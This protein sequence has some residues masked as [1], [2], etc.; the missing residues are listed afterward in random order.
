MLYSKAPLWPVLAA[1][2]MGMSSVAFADTTVSSAPNAFMVSFAGVTQEETVLRKW[3]V[4][5][6]GTYTFRVPANSGIKVTINGALLIDASGTRA[7]DIG[8]TI[9]AFVSLEAGDHVVNMTG[10]SAENANIP[11]ITVNAVGQDPRPLFEVSTGIDGAEVNAIAASNAGLVAPALRSAGQAAFAISG[12][13]ASRMTGADGGVSGVVMSAANSSMEQS[14][15]G[16]VSQSATMAEE[17]IEFPTSVRSGAATT[18]VASF[19][20]NKTPPT[21]ARPVV[22]PTPTTPV[23]PPTPTPPVITPPPT[24]SLVAAVRPTLPAQHIRKPANPGDG[25][26]V[27]GGDVSPLTP[28]TNPPLTQMIQ[29]TSIDATDGIVANTGA[30][31]FGAVQI[32]ALFDTIEVTFAPTVRTEPTIVSVGATGQFAVRMFEE[33]FSRSSEVRVTLVGK[34]SSNAAMSS[35]PVTY[36]VTGAPANTGVGKALSRLTFGPTPE[37]YAR[38]RAIGYEAFVREQLNPGSINNRAFRNMQTQDLLVTDVN[39]QSSIQRS[40]VHY[41]TANAMFNP[42][43]LQEVMG[44]FWANHFHAITKDSP[45]NIQ[46]QTDREFFRAN[47]LTNFEDMLLYSAKSPLMS[48]YLDNDANRVDVVRGVQLGINENY[49]REILELHTVGV[50]GGYDSDDIEAVAKIFTGWAYERTNPMAEQGAAQLYAFRFFPERHVAGPK[51]VPFLGVTIAERTGP[52]GVQ[53]GEELIGILA[54]HPSTR[55]FVCGKLV[56]FLVADQPPSNLIAACAAA[57]RASDGEIVPMLEAILL[58]PSYITTAEYQRNKVKNPFEYSVSIARAFGASPQADLNN[59]VINFYNNFREVFEAGG[60]YSM[61][62]AAPTGLPEVS[63]A[64]TSSATLAG[65]YTF[66]GDIA[67]SRQNYG[68][69]LLADIR[70]LELETAEEVAAYLLTVA[71]A[72]R[73]TKPEF[74]AVVDVLNGSNGFDVASE[75]FA[76]RNAVERAMG[77]ILVTPSFLLQ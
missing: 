5:S 68:I 32:D 19:V 18:G 54:Q 63:A 28:P 3:T 62:F 20:V 52:A 10:V 6:A 40:L 75:S 73:F 22:N 38:V 35:E 45:I 4:Q 14:S 23:T 34:M 24:A 49:A 36:T 2:S 39:T 26:D 70:D 17:K 15:L 25:V 48:Q 44:R 12:A 29:L 69:D 67:E 30:T 21:P 71:T 43:Q 33:D 65:L 27:R 16:S 7:D 58:D 74:D 41:D 76:T 77:L 47:S 55:S 64:W 56:Q 53:E 59:G 46:N 72:D 9:T 11:L 13:P 8:K 66:G 31:L 42:R 51:P 60:Y 1:V 61:L 57:W 50:D 37:L